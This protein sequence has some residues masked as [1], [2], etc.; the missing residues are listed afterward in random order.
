MF[1]HSTLAGQTRKRK[2]YFSSLKSSLFF[3]VFQ[4]LFLVFTITRLTAEEC[5]FSCNEVRPLSTLLRPIQQKQQRCKDFWPLN[6]RTS[7]SLSPLFPR[8]TCQIVVR[9]T[10]RSPDPK[11]VSLRGKSRGWEIWGPLAVSKSTSLGS[12][13]KGECLQMSDLVMKDRF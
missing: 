7:S 5:N 8:W 9:L 11:S 10:L 3:H 1:R 13:A 12:C 6:S 4:C 2:L